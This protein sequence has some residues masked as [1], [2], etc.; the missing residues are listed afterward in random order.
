MMLDNFLNI[1]N[2]YL[3]SFSY[4][5]IGSLLSRDVAGLTPRVM[6]IVGWP[7]ELSQKVAGT[8][9]LPYLFLFPNLLIFGLFTFMPLFMNFGFSLTD[10]ASINFSSR[11]FSGLD[12][13]AR[14]ALQTQIDTGIENMEDDKF[15]AAIV[16]TFIFVVF[17]VPIMILIA[18]FTAIVLNREIVG[19]KLK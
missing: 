7:I 13:L 5:L 9:V 19:R 17:Q 18:L 6:A 10:G 14:I 8:K 16:D 3:V 1:N 2:W 11:E 15:R 4:L 12:N